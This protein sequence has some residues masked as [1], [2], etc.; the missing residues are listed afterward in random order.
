MPSNHFICKLFHILLLK[1][2]GYL[3]MISL[4][5]KQMMSNEL[6]Y[7]TMIHWPCV[8]EARSSLSIH[9]NL[10]CFLL[11]L[12]TL[13]L[14]SWLSRAFLSLYFLARDWT[15]H[16]YFNYLILSFS[17]FSIYPLCILL[18]IHA[19]RAKALWCNCV[20]NYQK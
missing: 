1:W 4:I 9:F 20:L 11:L 8:N 15:H 18:C 2:D 17:F 10:T 12:Q 7:F 6:I 13:T 19:D 16:Q 14:Q 3:I 5:W